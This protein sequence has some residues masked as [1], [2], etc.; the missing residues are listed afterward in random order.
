MGLF[1]LFSNDTAEQAAAQKIAGL[2]SGY[3]EAS[4]LIGQGRDALSSNYA[5]AAQPFNTLFNQAQGGAGAYGDASGANGAAGYA[6]A[7]QNFQ[8]NPGYQF[9]LDQGLKAIDRGAASRGNVTSGNTLMAEQAY[10]TGL[11]N[12]SY[13]DYLAGLSP[14]LNQSTQAAQGLGGIYTGLGKQLNQSYSGQG[15]LKYQTEAGIGNANSAATLNNYNVG[16]NQF[17]ALMGAA[18]LAMG[19]P[20][21]SFG[22]VGA[23]QPNASMYDMGNLYAGT[24]SGPISSPF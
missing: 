7:L 21:T 6:R 8:T 10:G 15:G 17:N 16:A 24:N 9:Q 12:Q 22:N 5:T 18:Q 3:K 4:K 19:M 23:G 14:Y 11:A 2:Q 13:K 1:D 20:P